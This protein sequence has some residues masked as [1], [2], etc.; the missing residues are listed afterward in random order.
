METLR[1]VDECIL[2]EG[3]FNSDAAPGLLKPLPQ[4]LSDTHKAAALISIRQQS[5]TTLLLPF[6][7]LMAL[8]DTDASFDWINLQL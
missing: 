2:R 4:R 8:P 1:G 6:I 7:F 5:E 3:A